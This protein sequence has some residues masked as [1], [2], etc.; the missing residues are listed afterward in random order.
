MVQARPALEDK[1]ARNVYNP[2]L[3]K[4]ESMKKATMKKLSLS[5]ETLRELQG[6][7]LVYVPGG[8]NTTFAPTCTSRVCFGET[9][10][11]HAC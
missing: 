9:D 7:V 10:A 1:P 11:D 5:R 4:G 3:F 6:N 8:T 2:Y